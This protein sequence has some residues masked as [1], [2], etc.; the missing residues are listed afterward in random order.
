MLLYA[1]YLSKSFDVLA[2][3]ISGET[4]QELKV[5]HFLHLKTEKKA[6]QVFGDKL[7]TAENYLD[8]YLKSDQKIRQDYNTLLDFTRT[9]NEKLHTLKYLKV[10]GVY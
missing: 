5:S 10:R 3:A 8:S 2:I 6:T 7:L 1:S 4:K 9:L